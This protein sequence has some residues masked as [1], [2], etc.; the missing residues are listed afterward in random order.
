M[1][2]KLW[3]LRTSVNFIGKHSVDITSDDEVV[4]FLT[5]DCGVERELWNYLSVYTDI[6]N[7]TNSEGA[8]WTNQYG[9]PGIGLYI[10]LKARY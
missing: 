2:Y 9:I 4:S 10:G 8:W 7:I 5:I 3:T 1:P 6:R